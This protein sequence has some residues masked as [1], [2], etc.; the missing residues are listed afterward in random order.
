LRRAP[1]LPALLVLTGAIL[2]GAL[3]L[4]AT[5]RAP[6]LSPDSLKYL[7]LAHSLSSGLGFQLFGEPMT[8]YPPGYPALLALVGAVGASSLA[9]AS[10]LQAAVFSINAVLVAAA[11]TRGGKGTSWA[12]PVAVVLFV[13]SPGILTLHAMVWSEPAFIALAL[14]TAILLSE[15]LAGAGRWALIGAGVCLALAL[16]MRYAGIALVPAAVATVLLWKR[17][18]LRA[19]MADAAGLAA[20]ALAPL[21]VCL[22]RNA[23]G[24]G[25]STSRE[26]AFHPNSFDD[27]SQLVQTSTQVWGVDVYSGWVVLALLPLASW[28]IAGGRLAWAVSRRGWGRED[29]SA[30]NALEGFLVLAGA[31]Y[32]GLLVISICFLV[33]DMP[34]DSRLLSPLLVFG[35]VLVAALPARLGTAATR[36]ASFAVL[37]AVAALGGAN[38]GRSIDEAARIHNEGV[39]FDSR[40]WRESPALAAM[41]RLPPG[42]VVFTNGPEVVAFM[43]DH[44]ARS[45]PAW[46]DS[47][48]LK[49]RPGFARELS[50]FCTA[51]KQ[52]AVV[53]YLEGVNWRW[54]VP[55]EEDLRARCPLEAVAV[56]P[57]GTLYAAGRTGK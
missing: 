55:T 29:P 48:S 15:R 50:A 24:A 10:M 49:E 21:A 42:T 37:I 3:L 35:V 31:S 11:A 2:G 36:R 20:M 16:L 22:A 27:L 6:G 14:G 19:R 38:I 28:A 52:G 8:Q 17:T 53:L 5:Q 4:W 57:D 26:W 25:S 34:F 46:A 23:I 12:G 41:R 51:V 32:A 30:A 40:Y 44:E 43:A 18:P 9:R 13:A 54:E 47:M 33:A 56:F 1:L 39:G 7:L 45:I